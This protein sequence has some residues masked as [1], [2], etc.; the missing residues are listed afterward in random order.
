MSEYKEEYFSQI[1]FKMKK[2]TEYKEKL[3][4]DKK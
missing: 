1:L 3:Q 2:I 4:S